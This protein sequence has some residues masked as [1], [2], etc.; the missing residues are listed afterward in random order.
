MQVFLNLAMIL[1]QNSCRL[2]WH[3]IAC[4]FCYLLFQHS[5]GFPSFHRRFFGQLRQNVRSNLCNN[6]ARLRN[7]VAFQRGG[8]NGRSAPLCIHHTEKTTDSAVV[9]LC[10]TTQTREHMINHWVNELPVSK[11]HQL[12]CFFFSPPNP[13]EESPS[14]R[15]S[16]QPKRQGVKVLQWRSSLCRRRWELMSWEFEWRLHGDFWWGFEWGFNGF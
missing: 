11:Y 4:V 14:R 10:F 8:Q 15:L 16:A 2:F 6:L 7:A 12:W 5:H 3:D 9:C 13:G 1:R